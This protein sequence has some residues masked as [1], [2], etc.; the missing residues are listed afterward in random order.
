MAGRTNVVIQLA[1][2]KQGFRFGDKST[3]CDRILRRLAG[4]KSGMKTGHN[5]ETFLDRLAVTAR[6]LVE[7]YD[8][9]LVIVPHVPS[10]L[11]IISDFIAR[12][13]IRIVRTRLS[14]AGLQRGK[15]GAR[16]SF[17]LYKKAD[18]TL[19]MRFHSNVCSQGL[20]TPAF[21]LVSHD[22]LSGVY[23]GLGMDC[24][25]EVNDDKCMEKMESWFRYAITRPEE[26]REKQRANL[27]NLRE[28]TRTFH[29]RMA[30]LIR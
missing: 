6:R 13:P 27:I 12:L 4:N 23:A 14:V 24:Y 25:S 21:G 26:I 28:Q 10:D 5:R 22:Q 9:N 20:Q 29:L 2:D 19:G 18:V 15:D 3:L 11:G 16:Y 8:A 1:G 30:A 7:E 17:D